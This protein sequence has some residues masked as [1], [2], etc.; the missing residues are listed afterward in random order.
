MAKRVVELPALNGTGGKK[1][2]SVIFDSLAEFADY[3]CALRVDNKDRTRGRDWDSG[4]SYND[5]TRLCRTGDLNKVAP[6]DAFMRKF[7]DIIG[8]ESRQFRVVNDVAGGVPNIGAYLAG[9]PINMRRRARVMSEQAPLNVV[10]DLVSSGGITAKDLERRGAAVLALVRLLSAVRPVNLYAVAC[11]LPHGVHGYTSVGFAVRIDTAPL[12][13]ARAAHVLG[14]PA[15]PRNVMYRAMDVEAGMPHESST[16]W[17]FNDVNYYREHGAEY[18]QRVLGT[19]ECLFLA[20]P[21][22]TDEAISDP[23]KFIRDKLAKYG[24]ASL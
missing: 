15:V 24:T 19:E 7:E 21:Y 17:A 10:V 5:A 1:D 14:S 13:L 12:D 23:E 4:Q 8:F 22:V 6:S 9:N 3:A 20:P 2:K 18:W 11:G 16:H